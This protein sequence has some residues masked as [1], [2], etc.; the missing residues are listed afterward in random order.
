MP[1]KVLVAYG[2][3]YGAT[4]EIADRIGHALADEGFQT[5]VLS[6]EKVK[7]VTGYDG[8]VIG[9]A[10]YIGMWRKEVNNFIQKFEKELAARP[11]WIFSSGPAGKGD[12][13]QQLQGWKMPKAMEMYIDHIK[14]K[15][16]AIFHGD[17]R[18]EKMNWFEKWIMK[19]IKTEYG[20]FR[21]WDMITNWTKGIAAALKTQ[22]VTA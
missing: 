4:A 22:P 6:A 3:K 5:D 14:P 8:V 1:G 2:S 12:P 7:D 21:D 19:R 9:S 17:I 13:A 20:D 11:V 10:V 15:D 18:V 16:N